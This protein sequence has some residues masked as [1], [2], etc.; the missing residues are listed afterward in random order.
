VRE[1]KGYFAACAPPDDHRRRSPQTVKQGRRVVDVVAQIHGLE[2]F[3]TLRAE[4]SS[5]EDRPPL[6]V[7]PR[8]IDPHR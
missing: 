4:E 7:G 5:A 2:R 6:A 1:G 3:G 8:N